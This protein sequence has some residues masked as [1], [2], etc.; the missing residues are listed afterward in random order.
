MT[1]LPRPAL[2]G[3]VG[4][5]AVLALFMF[6]RSRGTQE[7]APAPEAPAAS[8]PSEKTPS[9]SAAPS[10]SAPS[11]S[12]APS[13]SAGAQA[14]TPSKPAV[15]PGPTAGPN[16][17]KSRTLP[18]PVKTALDK[19]KVV[20]LLIWNPRGGDDKTVKKAVDGLSRRNGKVAVFTD[21]PENLA[22]Y[23]SITAATELQQTPTV[24]FVNRK[25]VARKATGYLDS[26]TLDQYV[27]D[28]LAGAP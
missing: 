2:M 17:T 23:T 24:I 21:K 11:E 14:A 6:T 7:E 3:I 13:G 26:V 20:V 8:A 9:E 18:A 27:T 10:K 15:A 16:A 12:A 5:V 1:S 28:A 4:L 22:R 19:N 25:K